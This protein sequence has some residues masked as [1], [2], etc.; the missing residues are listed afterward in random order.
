MENLSH[1]ITV[2]YNA[3]VEPIFVELWMNSKNLPHSGLY[4]TYTKGKALLN[5]HSK[6]IFVLLS[7]YTGGSV[8]CFGRL[9][10]TRKQM[11]D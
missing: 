9:W 6:G 7:R 2:F 1:V 3:T 8:D 5:C 4:I 10:C 11:I